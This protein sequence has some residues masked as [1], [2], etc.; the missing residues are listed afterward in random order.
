MGYLKFCTNLC[1][2][3]LAWSFQKIKLSFF[4]SFFENNLLDNWI[5]PNQFLKYF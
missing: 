2:F 3:E 4:G 5:W 1:I